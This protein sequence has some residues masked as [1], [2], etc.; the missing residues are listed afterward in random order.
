MESFIDTLKEDNPELYNTLTE[1]SK[2]GTDYTRQEFQDA[3]KEAA[4]TE[5]FHDLEKMYIYN[6]HYVSTLEI[7]S[8]YDPNFADRSIELQ[9]ALWGQSVQ[10]G[11]E[12]NG[13]FFKGFE[14][15]LEK[16]N[17]NTEGLSDAELV[18]EW[19]KYKILY[20]ILYYLYR[21]CILCHRHDVRQYRSSL[22]LCLV[23]H[24]LLHGRYYDQI[25]F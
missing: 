22:L 12:L 23:V 7:I 9:Q 20:D 10:L 17:K 1:A 8:K 16:S 4:K 5:N 21:Y 24:C 18:E 14:N 25:V 6:T 15:E 3:W 13:N 11:K 19:Y 2:N